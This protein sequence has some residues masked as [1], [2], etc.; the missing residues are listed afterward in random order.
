MSALIAIYGRTDSQTGLF[1]AC[2]LNFI[3]KRQHLN[4]L[5]RGPNG[6]GFKKDDIFS[7]NNFNIVKIDI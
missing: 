1:Y 6:S 5:K 4:K 3:T 7:I 2:Q